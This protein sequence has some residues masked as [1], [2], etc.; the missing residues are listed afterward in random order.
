MIEQELTHGPEIGTEPF[1]DRDREALLGPIDD[2]V[3][4][5]TPRDLLEQALAF[6]SGHE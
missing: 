1:P 6:A 5:V 2:A 3:G 4:E